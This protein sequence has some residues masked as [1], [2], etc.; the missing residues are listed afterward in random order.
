MGYC[1]TV[2]TAA[3]RFDLDLTGLFN[4]QVSKSVSLELLR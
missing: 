1:I 3:E 4:L 2:S